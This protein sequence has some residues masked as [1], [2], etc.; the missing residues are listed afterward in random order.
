MI[1]HRGAYRILENNI[2]YN[3]PDE[4][5]QEIM[6]NIGNNNM[7]VI[8]IA[9]TGIYFEEEEDGYLR[10]HLLS[11]D[12]GKQINSTNVNLDRNFH[13]THVA[14]QAAFGTDLIKLVDIQ[15][16]TGSIGTND[17]TAETNNTISPHLDNIDI[18][19]CSISLQWDNNDLSSILSNHQDKIF[20]LTAGNGDVPEQRYNA[21][22]DLNN[23]IIIGGVSNEGEVLSQSDRGYGNWVH[24]LVPSGPDINVYTPSPF[25]VTKENGVSFGIPLVANV[26]AKMKLINRNLTPERIKNILLSSNCEGILLQNASQSKGVLDPV[27]A[28]QI[29]NSSI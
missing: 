9:D 25:G 19:S 2:D 24:I 22:K 26:I 3:S 13:G 21:I 23:C 6:N 20:L 1:H 8:G 29:A 12:I 16:Q 10:R 15:V 28:Y 5:F 11:L 4:E 27:R 7:V 17:R 18:L 14:G